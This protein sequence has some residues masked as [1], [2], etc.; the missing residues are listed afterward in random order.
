MGKRT[1]RTKTSAL[2]LHIV[3]ALIKRMIGIAIAMMLLLTLLISPVHANPFGGRQVREGNR[4]GSGQFQ[5]QN[6]REFQRPNDRRY[7]GRDV[8][9]PQR[10]SPDERRQLRR[11]VQDAGREIYPQRR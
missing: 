9:R 3:M 6:P 4:Q 10:L 11:D 1:I 2:E 7:E 5:P 8:Q